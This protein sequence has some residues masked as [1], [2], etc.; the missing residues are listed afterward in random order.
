MSSAKTHPPGPWNSHVHV[1]RATGRKHHNPLQHARGPVTKMFG[2]TD[3]GPVVTRL[4][5]HVFRPICAP[6]AAVFWL[7]SRRLSASRRP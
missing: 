3:G 6:V 5:A 2:S 1:H 7:L 4:V